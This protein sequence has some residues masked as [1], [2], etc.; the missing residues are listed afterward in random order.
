MIFHGRGRLIAAGIILAGAAACL[1]LNLPGHLSY[2]SVVQLAEGRA[3]VYN[4]YHPLVMSW[5]LGLAD[6]ATPGA[7]LFV[8][9][10]VGLIAG[11]LVALVLLGD[12]AG[13]TAIVL[14]AVFATL[15][16]LLV[17][18]A[19]VW[20]DVLFAAASVAGFASLALAGALWRRPLGRFVLLGFALVL[21][22]LAALARQNGAVVLPI[23]GVAVGWMAA[24]DGRAGRGLAHGAAFF[25]VASMLFLSASWA[26][27]ARL[28]GPSRFSEQWEGL[29]TYDLT[30][31]V[32]REPKLDLSV[33]RA[34][35][36]LV[37]QLIRTKG[38][39]AYSPVR[40]D[41]LEPVFEGAPT[42]E[43]QAGAIAAQWRDLVLRHPL[44]YLRLRATA[45]SWVFLTPSPSQC[46]IIYTGVDGPAEEMGE[47]RLSY[48]R[49]PRDEALASYGLAFAST[50]VFSHAAYGA[51]GAVLLIALMRRRRRADLAVAAML[52]SAMAFVATFAVI[53][54]ACDYRY[55]YDLDLSVIAA[56][57]YVAAS[58][59]VPPIRRRER[60]R[61]R[62]SSAPL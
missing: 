18:P 39:A 34:R 1:A 56:A 2:D 16:Q 32:V 36:P 52:A 53:S 49:T 3:G 5:L 48:R 61:G 44:L 26:L 42:S 45:L 31:A 58:F 40:V 60:Q 51:A 7:S 50:P 20:K 41:T 9:F 13:W 12:L 35:A 25:A 37:E 23:A 11:S 14:A 30:A 55:L 21:L 22:T 54:I 24:K 19:I 59:R 27:Q 38:A 43:A 29:Q 33:L 6:A 46:G 28:E 15:P 57:L 4:G 10:D 47:A 17:Y 62:P 8:V